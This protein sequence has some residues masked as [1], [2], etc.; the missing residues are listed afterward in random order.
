MDKGARFS[1]GNSIFLS[2]GV[3]EEGNLELAVLEGPMKGQTLFITRKGA[4][5]GRSSDNTVCVPDRSALSLL[6]V[7]GVKLTSHTESCHA[8]TAASTSTTSWASSW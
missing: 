3:N 5:F 6:S 7:C 2:K 4:T 1:A 8:S